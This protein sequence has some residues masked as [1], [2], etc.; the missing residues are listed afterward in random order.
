MLRYREDRA[1]LLGDGDNAFIEAY[2][3]SQQVCRRQDLAN[4]LA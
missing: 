1:W 4:A 3:A 2:L